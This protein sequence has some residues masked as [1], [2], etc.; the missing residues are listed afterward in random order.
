[1]AEFGG[2]FDVIVV[3]AGHAGCEAA[4]A[5]ARLG[6]R[7]LLL[8]M[9]LD[10]VAAMS[11]NPAI[12]GLAKGHLV[13]EIDALGG[14]MARAAD[15][16]GIQF[17]LLNTSKGPAVQ[18]PRAQCDKHAYRAWMKETLEG[19][20]GLH[21]KQAQVDR[22]LTDPLGRQV[23]GV[24]T[25]TGLEYFARAVVVTT[26]TFLQGIIHIGSFQTESGRAGEMAAVGLSASLKEMG[27]TLGRLKTGTNPRVDR[28]TLD[29]SQFEEFPG[30]SEIQP[31]SFSTPLGSLRNK[32]SCWTV[33][34]NEKVHQAIRDA[35]GRSP[36]F[37]GT[38]QGVGPRYCP[39]I[40]D[41]VVRFPDKT[42]HQIILEPEGLSTGELYLNGLSTSLPEADQIRFLRNLPGFERAEIMRPGYAVEY[43]FVLPTQLDHSLAV[44]GWK[45]LFLAGQ[46]NGTSGYEEAA[47]QGLLAGVNAARFLRGQSPLIL[48]RDEAYLGVLIDDLVS[49]GTTEPYRLFT[50]LAEFRLLLRQDNADLRL[51]DKGAEIGLLGPET[52]RAFQEKRAALDGELRRLQSVHLRP[53]PTLNA[54]L[55]AKGSPALTE[56]TTL[57]ALLRRSELCWEDLAEFE[58]EGD[59]SIAPPTLPQEVRRQAEI[60]VKYDGYIRRQQ[61]QV[62]QFRKLEDRLLPPDAD[63]ALVQG[64]SREARQK[65]AA[66]RPR[67]LGQAGRISG[68]TPADVQVLLVYLEAQKRR[69]ES[70]EAVV[71]SS[72]DHP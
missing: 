26:G 50:S 59:V 23:L 4:H 48:G 17:K 19:V 21:L 7:V 40:E 14:L 47:A 33:K 60:Q 44:R 30:D 25:K 61:S 27:L 5:G 2:D 15:A 10:A 12:G 57:A 52:Y 56:P 29:F 9:N 32:T 41:K 1:M 20:P 68:V 6:L 18:A 35:L 49:K 28:R 39:S 24:G 34:T 43:D 54:R 72:K 51:M 67:S 16:N 70:D 3:G 45:G 31:F 38:I 11:C 58:A 55:Q 13:R 42:W 64:L 36:L 22:L 8:G 63:Y 65:L 62:L 46:I 53:H 37:N 69:S 71:P 66:I